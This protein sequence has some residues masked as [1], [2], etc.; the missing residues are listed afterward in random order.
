MCQSYMKSTEKIK[1]QKSFGFTISIN[2]F[3]EKLFSPPGESCHP[4]T[5]PIIKRHVF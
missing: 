4:S 2:L 1:S 3:D 5:N